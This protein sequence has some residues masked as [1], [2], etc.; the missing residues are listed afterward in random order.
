MNLP[1][2]IQP[3]ENLEK[4]KRWTIILFLILVFVIGVQSFFINSLSGEVDALKTD[5]PPVKGPG[6]GTIPDPITPTTPWKRDLWQGF[7]H[8][9]FIRMEEM[10]K[11][12]DEL[13]QRSGLPSGFG[14]FPKG[15][16]SFG[17][18]SV[19]GF[20]VREEGD[21]YII[22]GKIAGV[23]ESS[24]N[25]T[26]EGRQLHIK[27]DSQKENRTEDDQMGKGFFSSHST[28]SSRVEKHLTLPGEVDEAGMEVKFDNDQL[29][30][31]IP[32]KTEGLLR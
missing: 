31:S 3:P 18:S 1:M 7:S 29:T 14:N 10:Q 26:I 12:M 25:V 17:F 5:N 23:K 13:M 15:L 2:K 4:T 16:D 22:T 28:F 9:P 11:K 27:S 30:I 32:K 6:V 19:S 20:E 8:D 24:V 21:K